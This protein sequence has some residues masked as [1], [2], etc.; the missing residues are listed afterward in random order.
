MCVDG[1]ST[2][3]LDEIRLQKYPFAAEVGR[4]EPKPVLDHRLDGLVAIATEYSDVRPLRSAMRDLVAVCL[5]NGETR[6]R[7]EGD[8]TK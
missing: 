1:G 6:R 5:L 3:V 2:R 4:E 7:R 8:S